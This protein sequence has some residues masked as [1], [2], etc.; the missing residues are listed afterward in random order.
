MPTPAPATTPAPFEHPQAAFLNGLS[1]NSSA[2]GGP[3]AFIKLDPAELL[4]T[5][6]AQQAAAYAAS[7]QRYASG[8]T[9]PLV[10]ARAATINDAA[11]QLAGQQDPAITGALNT[12][13]LG[14]INFGNNEFK[15]AQNL[16]QPI[17][18]K[19][20][21]DRNYFGTLLAQNQPRDI[22]GFNSHDLGEVLAA[23]SGN[24]ANFNTA[25][26]GTQINQINANAAAGAQNAS[27]I[28]SL[29]NPVLQS[30]VR[31]IG[32][33]YFQQGGGSSSNVNYLNPY[34]Y[35]GG[36]NPAFQGSNYGS[37]YA[38]DNLPTSDP[39][40]QDP[41]YIGL[42]NSDTSGQAGSSGY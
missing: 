5:S 35:S 9:A 30:G 10:A 12:A 22:T 11:G 33:H 37:G 38:A 42:G 2:G 19:E 24:E 34:D 28:S 3:P 8:Y 17:L 20:Q 7:D 16:G 36:Y 29:V 41:N 18:A 39:N 26:L 25:R 15:Q 31:A 14:N 1:L 6:Q 21:R 23:N 4:K 40:Y 27:A 32:N 13:G